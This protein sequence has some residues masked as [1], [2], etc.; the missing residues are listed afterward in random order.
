M[1]IWRDIEW[2]STCSAP[3]RIERLRSPPVIIDSGTLR[4]NRKMVVHAPRFQRS[5]NRLRSCRIGH[6]F[7]TTKKKVYRFTMDSASLSC[8]EVSGDGLAE[9][10]RKLALSRCHKHEGGLLKNSGSISNSV[11]GR[12]VCQ[13]EGEGHRG[14][15]PRAN[16]DNG[17][18]LYRG[19]AF[20][21]SPEP[22][23]LRD[24]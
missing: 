17:A 24:Y 20:K 7:R 1:D 6:T 19:D 10:S 9:K 18:E 12:V 15:N 23:R 11:Y 13:I 8:V 2:R 16:S 4:P 5:E 3:F 22:S 14:D 21:P